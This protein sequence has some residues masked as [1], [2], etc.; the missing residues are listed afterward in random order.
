MIDAVKTGKRISVSRQDKGFT[1]NELAS[2]LGITP[3]AVSRW[4]RGS[5]M[6]DIEFLLPLSQLLDVPVEDIL[7][8]G[9]TSKEAINENK[10]ASLIDSMQMD[11]I[12]LHIG[13][14]IIPLLEEENGGGLLNYMP[15]IR[16]E[17]AKKY[18]V[19][20][21]LIRLLDDV[22]LNKNE[23]AITI[24][25]KT[26]AKEKATCSHSIYEHFSHVIEQNLPSLITR[27]MVK[28]LTDATAIKYPITVEEA[29]PNRISYGDLA[30]LIIALLNKGKSVRNMYVILNH[31]CN[32]PQVND[33][34][35]LANE[36]VDLL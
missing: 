15:K 24:M 32:S 17:I 13:Y 25:G 11:E 23:Y 26:V 7:T 12:L 34:T 1:Q 6:P 21:P 19:I 35:L 28:L 22:N 29:V 9:H 33:I 3:Q 20:I 16:R 31:I 30:K 2:T 14:E 27:E 8:G 18:G 5:S 4:E 36:I 10:Q